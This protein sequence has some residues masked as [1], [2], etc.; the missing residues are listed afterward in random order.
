MKKSNHPVVHIDNATHYKWGENCDGWHFLQSDSLSVI[1]ESMPPHTSEQLH[2]HHKAQQ[3][4]FII[5]GI[6]S[7]EINGEKYI[8]HAD[9]GIAV[10]PGTPH[11]ISNNQLEKLEFLVISEPKSHGDRK[12]L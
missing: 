4:F 9:E 8:V 12:H 1:R 5:N 11:K 10:S 3:F 6:A 7:F 2:L